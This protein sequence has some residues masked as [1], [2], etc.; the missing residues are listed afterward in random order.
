MTILPKAIYKFNAVPIKILMTL[1][2]ELE[3]MILKLKWN[4]KGSQIA[5]SILRKKSKVG[6][7]MLPDFRQTTKLQ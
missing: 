7:I 3:Q 5:K 4:H 1:F 2:M 6:G